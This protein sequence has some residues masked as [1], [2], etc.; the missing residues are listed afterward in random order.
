MKLT[1]AL[2]P[3]LCLALSQFAFSPAAWTATAQAEPLVEEIVVRGEKRDRSLMDTQT[4]VVLFTEE[5]I[6]AQAPAAP[7]R[8]VQR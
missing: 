3:T 6:N 1:P 8:G 7:A 5:D 4:S 2:C